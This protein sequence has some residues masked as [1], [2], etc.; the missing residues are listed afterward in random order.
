[1]AS[2]SFASPEALLIARGVLAHVTAQHPAPAAEQIAEAF[3][4][5]LVHLSQLIGEDGVRALYERSLILTRAEYPWLP[6][7]A[8]NPVQSGCGP[9]RAALESQPSAA[10]EGGAALMANLLELLGKF[11]GP[12]LSMRL[13]PDLLTCPL[14]KVSALRVRAPLLLRSA[15]GVASPGRERFAG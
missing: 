7:A 6:A 14:G 3:L 1:L 5:L 10:S 12:S 8:G 15:A 4:R 9:L 2:R 13:I 11:I